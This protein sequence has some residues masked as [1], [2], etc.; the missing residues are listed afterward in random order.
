MTNQPDKMPDAQMVYG[1]HKGKKLTCH[2]DGVEAAIETFLK[3]K[4]AVYFDGK[5]LDNFGVAT[6]AISAA[7]QA[8]IDF[9][10]K[11]VGETND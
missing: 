1:E 10:R 6:G 2:N 4:G 8:Y 5:P 9:Y 3:F 7:I 11:G